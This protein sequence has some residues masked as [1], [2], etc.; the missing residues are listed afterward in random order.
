MQ[1]EP[2]SSHRKCCW[3]QE[4]STVGQSYCTHCSLRHLLLPRVP[5]CLG[6]VL[7]CTCSVFS[8]LG[9]QIFPLVSVCGSLCVYVFACI[10]FTPLCGRPYCLLYCIHRQSLQISQTRNDRENGGQQKNA[11]SLHLSHFSILKMVTCPSEISMS[12]NGVHGVVSYK[13]LY[14]CP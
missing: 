5:S 9:G 11:G 7:P 2:Y 6:I 3:T 13:I 14:N 12:F 8:V 10:Q 4:F 1:R